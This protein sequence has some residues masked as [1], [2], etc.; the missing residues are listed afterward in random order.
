MKISNFIKFQLKKWAPL[1]IVLAI[2]CFVFGVIFNSL[3]F[4]RGRSFIPSSALFPT[5]IIPSFVIPF[6][7]FKEQFNKNMA[8]TVNAFPANKYQLNRIKILIGLIFIASLSFFLH[9]CCILNSPS[10]YS[11]NYFLGFLFSTLS[12]CVLYLLN[13][14][15]VSLGNT[16]VISCLYV[17]SGCVLL[18]GLIPTLFVIFNWEVD[19]GLIS[20]FGGVVGTYFILVQVEAGSLMMAT[21]YLVLFI[22]VYLIQIGVGALAFFAKQPSGEYYGVPGARNKYHKAI[23]YSAIGLSHIFIGAFLGRLSLSFSSLASQ[24]NLTIYIVAFI[25]SYI[26]IVIFDKKFKISKKDWIILGSI[27]LGGLLFRI[28]L[29]LIY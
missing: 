12:L 15:L 18:F 1:F 10:D 4:V 13:C 26:L 19:L 11:L 29:S 23:I 17:S 20:T 2:Y 27:E 25:Y 9:I 22:F 14:T 5:M 8:D 3:L 6:F 16:F 28:I 7:V 21:G 24:L